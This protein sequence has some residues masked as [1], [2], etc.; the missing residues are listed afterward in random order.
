MVDNK[1]IIGVVGISSVTIL[2]GIAWV[3]GHN[4]TVFA[5]T[6]SI[7]G[8]ICGYFLGWERNVKKTI[9]EYVKEKEGLE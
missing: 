7:I 5:L 6:S 4:G 9:I 1:V 2:Q 8:G 3:T